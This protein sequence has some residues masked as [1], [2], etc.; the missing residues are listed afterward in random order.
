MKTLFLLILALYAVAAQDYLVAAPFNPWKYH[1]K[2]LFKIDVSTKRCSNLVDFN[3]VSGIQS[4]FIDRRDHTYIAMG[5]SLQYKAIAMTFN[6]SNGARF[7]D[8]QFPYTPNDPRNGRYCDYYKYVIAVDTVAKT[9]WKFDLTSLTFEEVHQWKITIDDVEK[10]DPSITLLDVDSSAINSFT[11]MYYLIVKN[12]TT[13]VSYIASLNYRELELTSMMP[14]NV[15]FK[16]MF[17]QGSNLWAFSM[18]GQLGLIDATTGKFVPKYSV[19]RLPWM[20]SVD[21]SPA[22]DTVYY[23]FME[24]SNYFV[25]G[26]NLASGTEVFK[27]QLP[28]SMC[29][30]R[31]DNY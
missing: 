27:M 3:Q 21:Y 14:I 7:E 1:H 28:E 4:A 12:V 17:L 20:E 22:T 31:V 15:D 2:N 23:S 5:M 9:V 25:A 11:S 19:G 13:G 16:G 24:G 10:P 8:K 18:K 29:Y 6:T 30:I 26:L